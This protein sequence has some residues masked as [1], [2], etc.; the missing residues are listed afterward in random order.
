MNYT[1]RTLSAFAAFAVALSFFL[2]SCE[3]TGDLKMGGAASWAASG[4]HLASEPE[5][6]KPDP[7]IMHHKQ[8]KGLI[9]FKRGFIYSE[10]D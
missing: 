5:K 1:T 10:E 7:A 3:T 2:T 9:T 4:F 6:Q 8:S